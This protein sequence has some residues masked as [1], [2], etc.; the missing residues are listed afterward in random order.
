MA[1]LRMDLFAEL[2]EQRSVVCLLINTQALTTTLSTFINGQRIS[3]MTNQN[4]PQNRDAWIG[5]S[6]EDRSAVRFDRQLQN[7]TSIA[8]LFKRDVFLSW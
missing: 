5:A 3:A 1:S 8:A 6:T 4:R 2:P 7:I